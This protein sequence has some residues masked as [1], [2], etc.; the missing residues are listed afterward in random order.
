MS[1]MQVK[2]DEKNGWTWIAEGYQFPGYFASCRSALEDYLS[3]SDLDAEI[4]VEDLAAL[5]GC[6]YEVD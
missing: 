5:V 4:S 6:S 2:F 1:K 3:A